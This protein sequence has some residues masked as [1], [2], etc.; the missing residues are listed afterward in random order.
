[1]KKFTLYLETESIEGINSEEYVHILEQLRDD[2]GFIELRGV[3]YNTDGI[4][5]I[6]PV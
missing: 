5:K 4:K 6:E 2:C 3:M 1:M